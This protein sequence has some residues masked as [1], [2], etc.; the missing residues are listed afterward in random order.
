[1]RHGIPQVINVAIVPIQPQVAGQTEKSVKEG[2][3]RPLSPSRSSSGVFAA[4]QSF[5]NVV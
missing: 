3:S 2:L 4:N 1:V 5:L